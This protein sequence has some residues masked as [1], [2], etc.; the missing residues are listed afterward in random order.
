MPNGA[1]D[2]PDLLIRHATVADGTGAPL[3]EADVAVRGGRIAAIGKLTQSGREEID[4]RGLLLT[5]GFVDIH[6][7]YDGQ[8]IWDSRLAPSSWHGVTTV[9]MGNCGVG[10]AP[11]RRADRERLIALM[12]GV[13]D[14][15][16]IALHEG[17]DWQW[18]SF[19]DYLDTLERRPRDMDVCA[20]LPHAPLRLYV[21]GERAARLEP[22]TEQ[23]IAAMRRLTAAA[24]R[25]GA[26]GFST[27]RTLN[28][29][30]SSGDSTFSL[31]ASEAE[32]RGIAQG[33]REAGSGVIEFIS[34]WDTPS[35]DVE[36]AMV[37]R[38]VRQAGRP[39]SFS[40]AER[41]ATPQVWRELLARTAAA[42]EAGL[43]IKGQ[44]A[45]RA[46]GVLMGL[47]CSRNPFSDHPAYKE[48]AAKPLSERL[49]IMRDPAFRARL[50]GQRKVDSGDPIARRL[51]HFDMI[52]PLGNPPNYAPRAEDSI[53]AEAAQLGR[54][55]QDVAY[56]RL[57]AHD[58]RDFLFTPIANYRAH[59]L[60]VCREMLQSPHTLVGLGDGGAHVG[61]I[62][63]GG[64]PT[65]LLS[66][67]GR[68]A[69]AAKL[70]L[71]GLVKRQTHDT[72]RAVGLADRGTIAPGMKADLNLID[73]DRLDA[74]LPYMA[75]DLPA[76]GNRLLQRA[77]GYV[78]TIV[79]G[80]V[81]YRDG[82][83]TAALPGRLVRAGKTKA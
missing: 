61:F 48:I 14:I 2:R 13:E 3:Y 42:V 65:F 69:G 73:F 33:L 32:L 49:A 57:I 72:A 29:R 23:D 31:R 55:P 26:I 21:M 5:P 59:N 67:W 81:T 68:D 28:H 27:S 76:G 51:E 44:V 16:G 66:Y 12:E 9:V 17:L 18:E 11:A 53:A 4:A 34:D 47:Q 70:D 24:M 22:A 63:D 54:A 7:H 41:H 15:P 82:E 1:N 58:G 38:V 46:V 6:T 20:Q 36:F 78:A 79:S 45:P 8:A 37:D 35:L 60:D 75:S 10:F 80:A 30:S 62:C 25:A 50:L 19:A 40:L 74:G 83:P 56:D 71:A 64:Y 77:T 52:F 43:P 39:F